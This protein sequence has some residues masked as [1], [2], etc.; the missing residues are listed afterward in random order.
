MESNNVVQWRLTINLGG[1]WNL[2]IND[3]DGVKLSNF[4]PTCSTALKHVANDEKVY[5]L[6][7]ISPNLIICSRSTNFFFF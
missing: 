4:L 6:A 3:K 2:S 1:N 7:L 5:Y